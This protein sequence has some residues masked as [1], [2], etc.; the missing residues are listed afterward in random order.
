[1][2]MSSIGSIKVPKG[3]ESSKNSV[4]SA[5]AAIEK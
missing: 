5:I 4:I 3:K 1:M 2:W